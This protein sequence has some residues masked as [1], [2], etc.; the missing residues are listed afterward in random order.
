MFLFVALAGTILGWMIDHTRNKRL[1]AEMASQHEEDL[2]QSKELANH[3]GNALAVD[4]TVE[5]TIQLA[6]LHRSHPTETRTNFRRELCIAVSNLW[7]AKH[8]YEPTVSTIH[9]GNRLCILAHECLSILECDSAD[10][11]FEIGRELYSNNGVW[12]DDPSKRFGN[13][14]EFREFV[15]D[16]L[17]EKHKKKNWKW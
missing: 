4:N 15:Q 11:Y 14:D 9:K 13:H 7:F 8:H 6:R 10:A 12:S 1:V 5:T 17:N 16:S 3:W 2:Q